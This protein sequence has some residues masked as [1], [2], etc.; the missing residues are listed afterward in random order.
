MP[1]TIAYTWSQTPTQLSLRLRI[2][3]LKADLHQL[4]RSTQLSVVVAICYVRVCWHP[5]VLELDLWDD[6]VFQSAKVIPGAECLT[7]TVPKA[8]KGLW[9]SVAATSNPRL[10]Q[11]DIRQRR[12]RAI[13]DYTQWQE[14]LNRARVGARD[15][16]KEAQQKRLWKQQKEQREWQQRQKSLQVEQVLQQ[17]EDDERTT[18]EQEKAKVSNSHKCVDYQ[19]TDIEIHGIPEPQGMQTPQSAQ[20]K[21]KQSQNGVDPCLIAS[22]CEDANKDCDSECKLGASVTVDSSFSSTNSNA[23]LQADPKTAAD[24][25]MTY[26]TNERK[27]NAPVDLSAGQIACGELLSE[28]VPGLALLAAT[29]AHTTQPVSC[30]KVRVSFGPRRPNRVPARGPRVPPLPHTGPDLRCGG[31]HRSTPNDL[32]RV[33]QTSPHWLQSKAARLLMCGDVAAAAE[34]YATILQL[35]QQHSQHRLV[36]VKALCGRSLARLALGENREVK[37]YTCS[38]FALNS[39]PLRIL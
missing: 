5:W 14:Q 24:S 3:S 32:S 21:S 33:L 12:Q 29:E 34:A 16:L 30:T 6:V 39:A 37:Q 31:T 9:G 38:F 27:R 17:I 25:A 10:Q 15:A 11:N 18:P 23:A 2:P 26:G 7:I 13:A 22:W 28:S 1:N 8:Q 20:G 4:Q 35:A 19:V 36:I